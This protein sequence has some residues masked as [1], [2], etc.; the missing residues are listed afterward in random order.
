MLLFVPGW[1]TAESNDYNPVTDATMPPL[2]LSVERVED[3][4]KSLIKP[5]FLDVPLSVPQLAETQ[6]FCQ[7]LYRQGIR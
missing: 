4:F 3:P 7:L 2:L 5:H 1:S 6:V